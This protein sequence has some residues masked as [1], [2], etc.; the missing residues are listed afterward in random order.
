[1]V[2]KR[3]VLTS[4]CA[5]LL[6]SG[7]FAQATL[8]EIY[9][10]EAR[11]MG[12]G[13]TFRSLATGYQAFFGNPAGF[14]GPAT[15]TIA[16]A[17]LWGYFK[18]N[19]S[20]IR[21]LTT[22]AQGA[23]PPADAKSQLGDIIVKNNGLGAGASLGFGWSGKGFGLGLTMI[24]DSLATGTTYNDAIA[25]V[26]NQANAIVGVA[27]PLDLGP[28]SINL[29]IDMR[30][31]YR[32]DSGTA[33]PFA[34]LASAFI[35]GQG[36][37]AEIGDLA[38]SGGYGVAVDSGA[39]LALGPFSA[40]VMIRDYGYEFTMSDTTVGNVTDTLELPAG[41]G[42]D[43][44]YRLVPNYAVGMGLNFKTSKAMGFSFS[45]ETDNP[46][47]F[48]ELA[49]TDL[50][51]SLELLHSGAQIK[52]FNVLALR[53]G[54]NKGLLSFGAGLDLALIEIDAAVFSEPL[55]ELSDGPGR[56]GLALQTA[57]RF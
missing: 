47:A 46:R 40:G 51:A 26:R 43:T 57:I 18:P 23:T 25:S 53:A 22:I 15:L 29:G 41:G 30:A 45:V 24:S 36:F 38:L 11:S 17:A 5:S 48:V 35:D 39:I 28:F 32:L 1:M 56:S 52:L 42:D 37:T 10:K 20:T 6:A 34:T 8:A 7:A 33:W 21:D 31:F 16:D 9:P 27:L 3:M 50:G 13:G 54:Y 12:M 55:A 19:P 2:F 14:S 4:L 49:H 44:A